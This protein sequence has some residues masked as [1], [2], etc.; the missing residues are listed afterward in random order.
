[1]AHGKV[2]NRDSLVQLMREHQK[3]LLSLVR[4]GV[5]D[6]ERSWLNIAQV[7]LNLNRVTIYPYRAKVMLP[8]EYCLSSA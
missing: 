3:S 7:E 1:M 8:Y 6:F 4:P 5:T 2:L